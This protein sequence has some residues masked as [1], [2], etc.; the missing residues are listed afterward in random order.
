M[1][2]VHTPSIEPLPH[3]ITAVY[4]SM[5]PRKPLRYLL[6]ND[7]GAGKTLRS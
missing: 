2:A 1:M 6:A 5:L 3:R 7:P 4:E